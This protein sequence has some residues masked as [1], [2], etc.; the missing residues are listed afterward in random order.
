M[1]TSKF[2][3]WIPST[4]ATRAFLI[5]TLIEASVDIGIEA[6]IF[7]KGEFQR[8]LFDDDSHDGTNEKA[9]L[10]VYLAIFTAAHLY[11]TILA[12]DALANKNTIQVIGLCI[13]NLMFLFYSVVQINEVRDAFSAIGTMDS[14]IYTLSLIVPIM[15]AC[16]EVMYCLLAWKLYRE[17]GWVI[18]KS[19]GA[20]RRI[21]KMYLAYQVFVCLCK[22][23]L[24]FFFAFSLQ[25]LLLVLAKADIERWLTLAAMPF[26]ICLMVAGYT[27]ARREI[28]WLMGMFIAGC[29][30][31]SAYFCFK[32]FRIYLHSST[33]EDYETAKA[34]LTVFSVLSLLLLL[35]TIVQSAIVMRNFGRGLKFNMTAK[36]RSAKAEEAGYDFDSVDGLHY[37]LSSAKSSRLSID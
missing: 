33:R 26:T 28:K 37:K 30:A 12:I 13:F 34:S 17:F 7:A 36:A 11:Q 32:L 23:D 14:M 8:S 1:S 18:F 4:F 19:L 9:A 35:F 3:R 31:G 27:A 22:F 25:F 16:T 20:D 15:I 10:P 24:F 2:S 6:V 29:V 5:I 21:K